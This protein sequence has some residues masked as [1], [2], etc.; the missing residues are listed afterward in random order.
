MKDW[1]QNLL[2]NLKSNL[3]PNENVLGLLLFGSCSRPEST[4]DEWSDITLS[5]EQ[6]QLRW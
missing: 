2:D 5:R 3:E 4:H 6:S 1:Q